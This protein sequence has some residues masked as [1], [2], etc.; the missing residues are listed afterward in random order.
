MTRATTPAPSPT[1]AVRPGGTS[2]NYPLDL[3]EVATVGAASTRLA[4]AVWT[5]ERGVRR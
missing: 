2:C 4:T 3:Q 1:D 5:P